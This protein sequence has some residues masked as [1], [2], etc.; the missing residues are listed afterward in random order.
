MAI[1]NAGALPI[2]DDIQKELLKLCEDAIFNRD[3][4]ATENILLFAE[5]SKN[6][7]D[8]K[9]KDAMEWRNRPVQER[10][11]HSLVKGIVEFI[12]EDTEEARLQVILQSNALME[13]STLKR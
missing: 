13:T 6:K 9:V 10:L 2:Y 1:V 8:G 5:A 3:P 11:A 7:A 12:I 4:N